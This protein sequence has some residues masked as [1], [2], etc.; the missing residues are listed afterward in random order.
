MRGKLFLTIV[1]VVAAVAA[2]GGVLVAAAGADDT[3]ALPDIAAAELI[4]RMGDH[5]R[6]PDAISGDISWTNELFGEMPFMPDHVAQPADSP[7]T[8]SGSGRM[9]AQDGKLRLESQGQ[10]G[11]QIV[12]ADA[13]AGT[14][15][16]YTFVDDTAHLYEWAGETPGDGASTGD[17]T[18]SAGE[19]ASPAPYPGS[20]HEPMTPERVSGFLQSAARFMSVE[21]TGT[22]VVAGRDA[23]LLTMTPAATDT[24]LGKVEAAIDGETYV[25]LRVDVVAKGHDAATLSFG[26]TRV[27]YDPVDDE[28]FAFEPPAGATVER[29]AIDPQGEGH[30]G[31]DGAKGAEEGEQPSAAA[32]DDAMEQMKELARTALLTR[33]EAAAL[34]D[35]PLAWAR[36]YTARDY[37]WAYVFEDGMPVNALGAPVFDLAQ[38]MGALGGESGPAGGGDDAG[39][40]PPQTGPA[41][42]LLYGEGFGSIVLAQTRTTD[43]IR[44]QMKQ[45]PE[46]VDNIDLGGVQAKAM[47]TPLGSLVVWERDGV[48]LVA[49]GMVPKADIVAFVTAVR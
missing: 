33:E 30:G 41:A 5:S 34:V 48:T 31:G 26:F 10:G 15:W 47:V 29:E 32:R 42:V 44:E 37:R 13:E 19:P 25:P 7:L 16:T 21:V 27:S 3:G 11:D 4:A 39:D 49:A 12:V 28:V 6:A 43:D 23:Y 38:M 2:L 35:F 36:E 40:S 22:T 45:L 8:A 17:D 18:A 14:L 24:A 1:L 46:V 9:W 20:A